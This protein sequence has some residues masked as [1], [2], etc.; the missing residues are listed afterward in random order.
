MDQLEDAVKVGHGVNVL[1][2]RLQVEGRGVTLDAQVLGARRRLDAEGEQVPVVGAV[3]DEERADGLVRQHGVGVL[4]GDG[5][6]VEAAL[7]ELVEG[8]EDHLVLG[9]GGER[10]VALRKPHAGVQEAAAHRGV[11]LAESY[12]GAVPVLLGSPGSTECRA[13]RRR[14]KG[15][16]QEGREA[17]RESPS[18]F[19]RIRSFE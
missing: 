4:A 8:G 13:D 10:L 7:L 12:H 6:P 5:G 19:V 9:L 17:G 15:E 3:P 14:K 16:V 11:K 2:V 1:G 18:T